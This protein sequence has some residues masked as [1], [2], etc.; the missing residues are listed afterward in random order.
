MKA[1]LTILACAAT[2]SLGACA[3]HDSHGHRSSCPLGFKKKEACCEKHK[4][5]SGCCAD[6][7]HQTKGKG[8]K[9]SACCG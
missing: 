6:Q 3:R 8:R 2:L 9:A 7:G 1:I 4:A 5:G